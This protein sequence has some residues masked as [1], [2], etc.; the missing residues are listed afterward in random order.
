MFQINAA[1]AESYPR[2]MRYETVNVDRVE[3]KQLFQRI[4]SPYLAS[5]L[6]DGRVFRLSF[7]PLGPVK[8]SAQ[9]CQQSQY[10]KL[11]QG[12]T[13]DP[14]KFSTGSASRFT[15]V[16]SGRQAREPEIGN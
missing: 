12:N 5:S 7:L 3:A 15:L 13:I 9:L 2:Q 1:S 16:M 11:R 4:Q 10:S 6:F 8:D 14:K